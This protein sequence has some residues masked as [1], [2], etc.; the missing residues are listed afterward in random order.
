[1]LHHAGVLFMSAMI[2]LALFLWLIA[3]VTLVLAFVYGITRKAEPVA[4]RRFSRDEL[5]RVTVQ[6]PIRNEGALAERVITSA[7]ALEYPVDRLQIQVVDDS[8]DVTT[9]AIINRTI[10]DV[11]RERPALDVTV[12]RRDSQQ[13][14]KA[15]ALQ[16][17]AVRATGEFFAVFDAD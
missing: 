1:M 4:R 13:G 6:L 11:R 17:G 9:S 16:Q 12:V 2:G 8:N 10:A 7:A 3:A 14:F 5:P 15:G